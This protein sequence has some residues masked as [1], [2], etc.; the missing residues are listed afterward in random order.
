M[1]SRR[2]AAGEVVL[3]AQPSVAV[4]LPHCLETHCASCLLPEQRC[5]S[6]G[7]YNNDEGPVDAAAATEAL[8]P[9][10]HCNA[11]RFCGSCRRRSSASAED[12][13][14]L[15]SPRLCASL[16]TLAR[17]THPERK[18]QRSSSATARSKSPNGGGGG[19][20]GGE[21]EGGGGE[22]DE[23]AGLDQEDITLATVLIHLLCARLDSDGSSFSSAASTSWPQHQDPEHD[24]A[25]SFSRMALPVVTELPSSVD[26]L[27]DHVASF[28]KERVRTF[29]RIASLAARTVLGLPKHTGTDATGLDDKSGFWECD[30]RGAVQPGDSL[31]GNKTKSEQARRLL[32]DVEA[33]GVATCG[34]VVCNAHGVSHDACWLLS[35]S[36]T[37]SSGGDGDGSVSHGGRVGGGG[38]GGGGNGLE[39]SPALTLG[40]AA[41]AVGVSAA[42]ALFNHSCTPTCAVTWDD[43]GRLVARALKPLEAGEEASISYSPGYAP[44]A[45][46]RQELMQTH[47]F[48]CECSKCMALM[49]G[50]G[51]TDDEED[52][53]EDEGSLVLRVGEA[54]AGMSGFLCKVEECG[55]LLCRVVD[56]P[57]AEGRSKKKKKRE[58]NCASLFT[59]VCTTCGWDHGG[60]EAIGAHTA[61]AT[62]VAKELSNVAAGDDP[63]AAYNALRL[64]LESASSLLHPLHSLRFSAH[65]KLLGF[66]LLTA[67]AHTPDLEPSPRQ[68]ATT[69][70]RKGN[71]RNRKNTKNGHTNLAV[72]DGVG[73]EVR[74]LLAACP[75]AMAEAVA[76]HAN[77]ALACLGGGQFHG[78]YSKAQTVLRQVIEASFK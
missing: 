78:E 26:A 52:D 33:W 17:L 55:G 60:R 48:E 44:T 67:Q 10:M 25:A 3:V 59:W 47:F 32:S 27:E 21:G 23:L 69:S 41:S 38:G 30:T 56:K 37:S 16:A 77:A 46:R 1:A 58:D 22:D 2:V 15:H 7:G 6:S 35:H 71:N 73:I 24:L 61:A 9:C 13:R 8:S 4:L 42:G 62:A 68:A 18:R 53:D 40:N 51:N 29:R 43:S 14:R 70:L 63:G 74:A 49:G 50:G 31:R 54:E 19:R 11:L 64:K 72:A 34:R 36:S 66:A 39:N 75:G 76:G 28:P 65:V 57:P 12:A 45:Q 20:T 5:S